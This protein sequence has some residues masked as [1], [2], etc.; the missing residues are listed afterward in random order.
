MGKKK[1]RKDLLEIALSYQRQYNVHQQKINENPRSFSIGHWKREKENFF[2][3]VN[4]YLAKA[5]VESL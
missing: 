1:S 3:R 4:Y 2:A 5:E